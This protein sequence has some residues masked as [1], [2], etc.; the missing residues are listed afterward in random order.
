MPLDNPPPGGNFA[1]EFSVSPIPWVTSS[2]ASGIVRYDFG[3]VTKSLLVKNVAGSGEVRVGFTAQ[4]LSAPKNNYFS[5]A[6]GESMGGDYRIKSLF[7]SGSGNSVMVL[8]GL[9]GILDRFFP[10]LT[11]S[12]GF[13]GVG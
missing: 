13:Q 12:N 5:L 11:G 8:V 1:A 4:G 9:T 6:V 3:N 2:V 10:L 7:I